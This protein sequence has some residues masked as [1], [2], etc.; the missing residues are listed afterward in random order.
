MIAAETRMLIQVTLIATL[1][2]AA[3]V[4]FVTVAISTGTRRRWPHK[5]P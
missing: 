1:L 4:A 3:T 5:W 2:I